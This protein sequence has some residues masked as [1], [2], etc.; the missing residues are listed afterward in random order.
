MIALSGANAA[1]PQDGIDD[2]LL[3]AAE[4]AEL[5]LA[6]TEL[7]VLS[8]CGTALGDFAPGEGT[9][10]L[11]RAFQ[12][13]GARTTVA[14]LWNVDDFAIRSQVTRFF[15]ET[16]NGGKEEPISRIEALRQ[17]QLAAMRG[18]ISDRQNAS[19]N[20]AAIRSPIRDWAAFVL[21]GDWR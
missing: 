21:S 20:N 13:A 5:P 6:K 11:Q 18:T 4:A 17:A 16:W 15:D 1:P 8:A 3:S 7:V 14:T 10:G 12:L 9:L 2:G 19:V